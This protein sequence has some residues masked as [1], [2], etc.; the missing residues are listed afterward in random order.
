MSKF[1]VTATI[2]LTLD[3]MADTEKQA[4]EFAKEQ[5]DIEDHLNILDESIKFT[6]AK[7]NDTED[8]NDMTF[9]SY[10]S[11]SD[12]EDEDEDY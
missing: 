2:T 4:L 8:E 6:K 10:G 11:D 3:V 12:D 9:D 1:K 7:L 5:F